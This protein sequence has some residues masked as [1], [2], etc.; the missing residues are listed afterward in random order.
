MDSGFLSRLFH[1]MHLSLFSYSSISNNFIWRVCQLSFAGNSTTNSSISITHDE[2]VSVVVDV[3]I[4]GVD[5]D[6]TFVAEQRGHLFKRN[7]FGFG[8]DKVRPD[9]AHDQ[10]RDED[11]IELP[12]DRP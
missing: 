12:S 6:F 10:D 8:K 2:L 3:D 7:A 5:H 4:R 11:E 9:E 1:Y